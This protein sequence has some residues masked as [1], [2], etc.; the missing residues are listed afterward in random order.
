MSHCYI[1]TN[2][3]NSVVVNKVIPFPG[4]FHDT[5]HLLKSCQ[6]LSPEV[7]KEQRLK[8]QAEGH[9]FPVTN[10]SVVALGTWILKTCECLNIS[11]KIHLHSCV[12]TF[13]FQFP[14]TGSSDSV[15]KPSL[16][17]FL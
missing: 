3:K 2:P 1:C 7:L 15:S 10:S 9:I 11:T 6:A 14:S 12:T 17:F 5:L 8:K 4:S 13:S 16:L